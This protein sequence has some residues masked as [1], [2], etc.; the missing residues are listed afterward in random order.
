[1]W[2]F[3]VVPVPETVVVPFPLFVADA[4]PLAVLPLGPVAVP[5]AVVVLPFV[6]TVPFAV[7]VPP[8]GPFTFAV[9]VA[10]VA[11][12]FTVAVPVVVLP[13]ADVAV[14][15]AVTV[16]PLLVAE[17]LAVPPRGPVVERCAPATETPIESARNKPAMPVIFMAN[18]L[19]NGFPRVP[20]YHPLHHLPL[21]HSICN[22]EPSANQKG[23]P[24][25][26][27]P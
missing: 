16:F 5:V 23:T 9:P 27:Q 26:A 22:A 25:P 15:V 21:P 12:F 18:L 4:L 8:F 14:P 10:P 20:S 11:V 6:F 17:L 19:V 3:A 1:V 24:L 13:R 7:V 2:P